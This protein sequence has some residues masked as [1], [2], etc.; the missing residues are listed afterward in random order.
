ML[1]HQLHIGGKHLS[2]RGVFRD[3]YPSL[4]HYAYT[5]LKNKHDAEDVAQDVFM[6]IWRKKP[7]FPSE[8]QFKAYLY[9]AT[10]NKAIDLMKKKS[11][12]YHDVSMFVA[13]EHQTD[14]L[15]REE[16]FRLLD[17]SIKLLPERSRQI[18]SLS[19]KGLSI[20]EVAAQLDITI[21]T[22]KTLKL[23]AYR[24][25]KERCVQALTSSY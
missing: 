25:L 1:R 12:A 16:A 22:V 24:F 17:E 15:I 6:I 3:Y 19:V 10:K 14:S 2:F 4:V 11:P 20:K 23:R 7:V 13:V 8:L 9:L 18:I 5:F 21:N